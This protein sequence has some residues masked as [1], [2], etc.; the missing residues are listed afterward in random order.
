MRSIP[1]TRHLFSFE[2]SL[3]LMLFYLF[4]ESTAKEKTDLS[5]LFSERP[6]SPDYLLAMECVLSVIWLKP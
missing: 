3:V 1:P 2:R 4:G 6:R 5:L